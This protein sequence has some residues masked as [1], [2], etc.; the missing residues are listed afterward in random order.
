MSKVRAHVII[1][2]KVQGVYFRA[3]TRDQALYLGV[4]G[5]IRNM[6]GRK[7]E[8]VF[9]GEQDKVNKLIEWC[10]QGPPGAEV[11]DVEVEWQ[12]CGSEFS[13]FKITFFKE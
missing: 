8:G 5:W 2:G 3:E 11:S 1:S 13:S 4:N 12:S 9:E 6:P 7:V 10:R